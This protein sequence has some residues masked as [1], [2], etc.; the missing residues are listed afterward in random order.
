MKQY[1]GTKVI[2]AKPMNRKEY[3]DLRGWLVPVDENAND[4][5][6]L[7][8]YVDGGQANHPAYKGY[9]SWSPKDVFERA[10]KSSSTPTDRM[11]LELDQLHGR[12]DKLGGFI[13]KQKPDFLTNEEWDLLHEQ[14]DIM[15]KYYNVLN[16][17]LTIAKSKEQGQ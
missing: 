5:G 1:T 16:T 7:V 13:S 15:A 2:N 10:Y 14:A 17:R 11:Q 12:M 9:I 8:E 6:Y 3:S 4:D